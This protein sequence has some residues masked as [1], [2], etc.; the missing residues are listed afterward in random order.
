[1]LQ[2]DLGLQLNGVVPSLCR[3]EREVSDETDSVEETI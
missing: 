1:M 2:K 3:L